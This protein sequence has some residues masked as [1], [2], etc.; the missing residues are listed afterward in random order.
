MKFVPHPYQT[1]M[2]EHVHDV[3]RGALWAG[4]GL[5][6][7]VACLSAVNDD[8]SLGGRCGKLLVLAPLRVAHSVWPPEAEKWD[9]LN[10]IRVSAVVGSVAERKA[11]LR[12][13]ANVYTMNYDNIPWLVEEVGRKWPFKWV[14]ADESTR[15]KNF[16]LKQG[17]RRAQALGRVAHPLVQRWTNLTGTP[18]PNGL[19]DLWGQTWFLDGGKRL[20]YSYTAF[21]QRWFQRNFDGYGVAPLPTAE[22]Q[23]YD[24]LSD[25]CLSIEPPWSE[26]PIVNNIRV[27][28]P[29]VA[30]ARYRDMEREM[31]TLL[32]EHEIEAFNA[33]SRTM[34]CL[35]LASGAAY[36]DEDHNWKE[37]HNAKLDALESIIEEAA[38]MP[39]LVSYFFKS[40]LARILKAFPQARELDESPR[41]ISD[42]NAG[43]IPVLVA[44]PASAG[45]GLNLQDG[46]N[47]IA[48]FD[49]WWD[50]ELYAQILERIGPVRQ[51]QSG[52]ERPV[53]VHHILASGTV[54]ELV[55]ARIESKRSVQDLLLEAMQR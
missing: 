17:G 50:L 18:S 25:V 15:L 43:R 28:L 19:Q 46:G 34:K 37:V 27:E 29:K 7:T 3:P 30:R 49:Q 5:G 14:I 53:Y 9:H 39:V 31:F 36:I 24:R 8:W 40:S 4:M 45:H 44:Q 47:I 48:Y 1:Q 51:R 20:G 10:N 2:M 11:A 35:Q 33:A 16:R 13:D 54:D 12:A 21:M 26:Q 32:G 41:T 22:Q 23:I 6:K 42:W 55:L 38:G 52:Y